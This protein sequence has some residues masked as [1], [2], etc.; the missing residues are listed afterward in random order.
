[1]LSEIPNDLRCGP[2]RLQFDK[3]VDGDPQRDLVPYYH[4]RVLEHTKTS[5][6]HINFRVGGTRHILQCAGHVGFEIMQAFRGHS[7]S[8][9][10]CRALAP[11][12]GRHYRTVIITADPAN[13]ASQRIIQKLG[14][15]FINQ[16]VVPDNDPAYSGG[17][18]HKLRY[19]WIPNGN[20]EHV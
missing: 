6:G 4:F 12:I 9:Y 19:E 1:M 10:A 5:V 11:F 15:S 8:Y 13:T 14:A 2:I 17:A 3:I 7:Y 20:I 16:I 18:R